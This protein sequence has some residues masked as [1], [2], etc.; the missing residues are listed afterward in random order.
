MGVCVLIVED[1]DDFRGMLSELLAS[2]GHRV[3]EAADIHQ[4]LEC[5]NTSKWEVGLIDLHLPNFDGCEVARRL[6]ACP[7]GRT[8]RLVALTGFSD[9]AS[10]AAAREAGFDEFIVK[11]VLPEQLFELLQR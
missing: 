7:Q 8:Q 10:R 6:R 5:A 1:D 11:P 2:V 3:L 4:A 9:E